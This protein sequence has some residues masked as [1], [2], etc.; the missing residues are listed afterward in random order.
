MTITRAFNEE[1]LNFETKYQEK[2]YEKLKHKVGYVT[3]E[4]QKTY[5]R[6]IR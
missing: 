2:L 5:D 4:K 3:I 1:K 6:T